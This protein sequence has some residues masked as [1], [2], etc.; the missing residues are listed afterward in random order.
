MTRLAAWNIQGGGGTRLSGIVD[1]LAR[2]APDVVVL[3]EMMEHRLQELQRSLCDVS[4][5]HQ[6][7]S[8]PVGAEYG[9]L[10]AAARPLRRLGM[11]SPPV[12]RNRYV[13]ANV[14]GLDV[15]ALHAPSRL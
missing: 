8:R 7:H 12:A 14:D 3:S 9:V 5:V 6:L 11:H 1:I 10:V 4:L 2:A 15:L 13:A